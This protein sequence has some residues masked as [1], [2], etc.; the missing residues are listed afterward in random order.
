MNNLKAHESLK[1]HI[2]ILKQLTAESEILKHTIEVLKDENYKLKQKIG[3]NHRIVEEMQLNENRNILE[4]NLEK[5]NSLEMVNNQNELETISK[6][7]RNNV[8]NFL[9]LY[10][11]G[12]TNSYDLNNNGENW[13]ENNKNN[14]NCNNNNQN[15]RNNNSEKVEVP[16]LLFIL[17]KKKSL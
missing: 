17:Y 1:K 12:T 13:K 15:R 6:K 10:N 8:E 3:N 16:K 4:N 9:Q 11:V 7:Y 14:K 5:A 2:D